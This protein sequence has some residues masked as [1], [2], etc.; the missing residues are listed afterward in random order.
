MPAM[1]SSWECTCSASGWAKIVLIAA[2]TI[3][4]LPFGPRAS[5]LRIKW[6][7]KESS[8]RRVGDGLW[9]CNGGKERGRGGEPLPG[10]HWDVADLLKNH[11]DL[12]GRGA[13]GA[14]ADLEQLGECVVSAHAAPVEQGGQHP[15]FVGDLLHEDPAAGTGQP[16]AAALSMSMPLGAGGQHRH[17]PAGQGGKVVAA[18]AGQRRVGESF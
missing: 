6:A 12:A 2:A 4:A 7:C 5:T 17:D 18:H 9:N 3:S 8:C 1:T 11:G 10:G 14:A 15:L 16:F 13:D